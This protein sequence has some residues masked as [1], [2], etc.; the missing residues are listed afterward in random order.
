ML[1]PPTPE[2]IDLYDVD[3]DEGDAFH[4][5]D[6]AHVQCQFRGG[7]LVIH[8]IQI[9]EG[10]RR[11]GVARGILRELRRLIR[12]PGSWPTGST[13]WS[14]PA[15]SGKPWSRRASSMRSTPTSTAR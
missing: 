6:V 7:D 1:K 10:V 13:G 15:G 11:T 12:T 3:A 5:T 9:D 8:D 2:Q 14:P 4:V